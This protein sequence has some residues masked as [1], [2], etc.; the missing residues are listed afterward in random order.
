MNR[1]I[2]SLAGPF[3]GVIDRCKDMYVEFRVYSHRDQVIRSARDRTGVSKVHI[4]TLSLSPK[5]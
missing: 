3:K 2:R 5:P 1:A 4:M